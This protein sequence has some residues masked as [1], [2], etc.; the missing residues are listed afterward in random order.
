MP[1]E[2]L[3]ITL[4]HS[5][6]VRAGGVA[7]NPLTL[8][9]FPVSATD[10]KIVSAYYYR[11]IHRPIYFDLWG[12]FLTALLGVYLLWRNLRVVLKR[13][14]GGLKSWAPLCDALTL[15]ILI[16]S[17]IVIDVLMKPWEKMLAAATSPLPG[18]EVLD[19]DEQYFTT[20]F[21]YLAHM[22]TVIAMFIAMALQIGS[23]RSYPLLWSDAGL[24]AEK[25]EAERRKEK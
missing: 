1:L 11:V 14:L 5:E 22:G 21:L 23:H 2:Y 7:C 10:Q 18:Q 13:G 4:L 17:K 24:A 19:E 15:V 6:R 20:G 25:A 9:S 12:M 8:K 3:E 16:T